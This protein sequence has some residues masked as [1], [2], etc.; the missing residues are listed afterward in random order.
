MI[1]RSG[2]GVFSAAVLLAASCTAGTAQE[3]PTTASVKDG[4]GSPRP[5]GLRPATGDVLY[6]LAGPGELAPIDWTGVKYASIPITS[7]LVEPSLDGR[8]LLLFPEVADT[9]GQEIASISVGSDVERDAAWS[10]DG[11][12]LCLLST[13]ASSGPDVGGVRLSVWDGAALRT[14]GFVGQ[15]GLIPSIGACAPSAGRIVIVNAVK[16]HAVTGGGPVFI[17][18]IQAQMIDASTGRVLKSLQLVPSPAPPTPVTAVASPDGRYLAVGL[19]SVTTVFDTATGDSMSQMN[20]VTP[21]GFSSDPGDTVLAVA[22]NP[23]NHPGLLDWKSHKLVWTS[24]TNVTQAAVSHLGTTEFAFQVSDPTGDV[25][26]L[27]AVKVDGSVQFL[28]HN[29]NLA[30]YCPCPGADAS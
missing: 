27:V 22:T 20:G 23:G 29:M 26:D 10:S 6:Y 3:S 9:T 25:Y 15:H 21:L 1:R 8:R 7:S 16:E 19:H 24:V 17:S 18:A 30:T 14:I 12:S 28:L 2:I 4:A 11:R 13:N 5:P